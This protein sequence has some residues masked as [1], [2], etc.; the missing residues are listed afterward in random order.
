MP[1]DSIARRAPLNAS[2]GKTFYSQG[3]EGYTDYPVL[4]EQEA[5]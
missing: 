1:G 2:D 4:A 5:A 3:P